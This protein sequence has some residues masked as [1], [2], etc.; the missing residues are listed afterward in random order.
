MG[1]S[2]PRTAIPIRT[3]SSRERANPPYQDVRGPSTIYQGKNKSLHRLGYSQQRGFPRPWAKPMSFVGH[4]I[5]KA[6]E[7]A[8][9]ALAL[10]ETRAQFKLLIRSPKEDESTFVK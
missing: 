5:P 8:F 10:D 3:A 9:Q 4:V 2:R 7:Y 1:E 6:V